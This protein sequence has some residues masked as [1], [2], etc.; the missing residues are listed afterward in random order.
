[1]ISPFDQNSH[2]PVT[3][4]IDKP[5]ATLILHRPDRGN[6]INRTLALA[7]Q[8]ALDDLQ[9]EKRVKAVTI[10]GSGNSFCT[11][12]DLDEIRLIQ[13]SEDEVQRW[14]EESTR[15]SELL[16]TLLRFPKP[17]IAAVNGPALG[18]G[19]AVA[20]A[21]DFAISSPNA[22][23]GLPEI[24]RGLTS[25]L[26]LPLMNFRLGAAATAELA[27]RGQMIDAEEAHRIGLIR[28]IV[29]HDQLWAK[30]M[31]I[32]RQIALGSPAAIALT[33]RVLNETVGES[34]ISQI[35]AAAAALATMRTT[36]SAAEGIQAFFE[37]RPPIWD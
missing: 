7:F 4:R 2:A 31:E 9:L 30:S 35:S 20:L 28:E 19:L 29:D 24:H 8:E 16:K 15:I 18:T 21:C 17:I 12:S 23:F 14:L 10:T 37:K 26:A 27:M 34:M 3:V 6:S 11:G 36:E 25:G 33:K 13:N 22:R 32:T 1:M 5:S